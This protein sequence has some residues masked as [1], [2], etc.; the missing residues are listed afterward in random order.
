[1]S[2]NVQNSIRAGL[3]GLMLSPT[4]ATPER[5]APSPEGSSHEGSPSWEVV[6]PKEEQ[7][8]VQ[9]VARHHANALFTILEVGELVH[10]IN[11]RLTTLGVRAYP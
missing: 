6:F 3:A 5:R 9:V 2:P 1:M 8:T 11:A 4:P 10:R 7:P